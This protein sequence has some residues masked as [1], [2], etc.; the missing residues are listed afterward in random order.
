[1]APLAPGSTLGILGGGQLGR[2]LSQA[3]SRLGF[4]VAILDPEENSPAG[5]VSQGQIVAAYDDPTALM[6]LGQ[7][8]Q[9]VTFEFENVPATSVERL[10]EGGAV[11]APGPRAL[12]VAQDRVEEKTFLNGVGATTVDFAAV[13][14]LDDLLTG[15]ERLGTPAVLKTRREGYDG[16]GQ[17]WVRSAAMAADAWSAVGQRPSVLEAKAPF[18]RELSIIAARG[19]DGAIA[20]YPLGENIHKG[21]VLKT[22]LAPAAVDVRTEKR[23][24]AI[25]KAVLEGLDYVGVLGVELFDLGDGRLLVNEIAPR[26]HNTGHWTQDGCV[27][28]QFEQHIRAIAGWPLGPTTAH[29]R[30][31]MTNLLGDE[32]EQWTRLSGKAD[33]R[34]HLYGKAEARPGRKMG[35]VNRV[36]PL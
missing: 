1:M 18:V 36:K 2:M 20:V 14:S 17:I 19:R 23:A 9:A 29:A 27:C 34:L 15:L 13:D 3:A 5:R 33:A 10:V 16:K 21:G 24:K 7:T 4:N 22:T 31:E 8:C 30:V 35:H 26:V 25:A 11:V 12:A 32:I 28:D 6:V